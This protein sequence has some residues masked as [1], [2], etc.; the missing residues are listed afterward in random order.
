MNSRTALVA[1]GV[2]VAAFLGVGGAVTAALEANT[3]FSALVGVP[4]G[5]LV[6]L[7]AAIFS[8]VA[9]SRGVTPR[10]RRALVGT[11]AAGYAGVAALVAWN[12]SGAVKS[13]A[14]VGELAVGAVLVGI[15][16]YVALV[17][18]GR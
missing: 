16:T 11:A 12:L 7:G 18:V 9:L 5:V 2:A 17:I 3:P 8:Y 10:F 6:G 1:L 15:V 13:A 14:S 4:S